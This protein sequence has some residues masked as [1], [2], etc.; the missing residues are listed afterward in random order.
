MT[1]FFLFSKQVASLLHIGAE[2]IFH[3]MP[4][5]FLTGTLS[6]ADSYAAAA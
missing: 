4:M 3:I 1:P 2:E 5:R 6:S